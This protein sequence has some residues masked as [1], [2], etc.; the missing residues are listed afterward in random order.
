MKH[1]ATLPPLVGKYCYSN[2]GII[3]AKDR[4]PDAIVQNNVFDKTMGNRLNG[5]YVNEIAR[6]AKVKSRKGS[7][8]E[9]QEIDV[10][11]PMTTNVKTIEPLL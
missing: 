11:V 1:S 7:G 10:I 5:A 2:L 4:R 3:Y 6:F 9:I 8:E